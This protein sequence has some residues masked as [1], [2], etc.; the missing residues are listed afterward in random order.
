MFSTELSAILKH[1]PTRWLSLLHCV[2]RYIQQLSGLIS[3][4]LSCNEQSSKVIF[5]TSR[6]QHPLTKPIL[7]LLSY[8][9]PSMDQFSKLFQASTENTTCELYIEM[10][11]LVKIY[12]GNLLKPDIII[13]AGDNLSLLSLELQDQLPDEI[14]ES[15][16]L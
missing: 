16:N 3:Y 9:L 4:F 10:N 13:A 6:L 1:C 15:P 5:I 8:I 12:A 7:L 14:D 2:D 11:Q